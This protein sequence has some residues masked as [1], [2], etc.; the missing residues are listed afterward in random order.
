MVESMMHTSLER[1][2]S[3]KSS[4]A[5]GARYAKGDARREEILRG[6]TDLIVREGY[7]RQSLRE[8]GAALSIEPA[9]ILYYFASREDLLQRVI[10]LWDR[11]SIAS[12]SKDADVPPSLDLF[13]AAVRR[14]C[15]APGIG[16]LF[17]A[18]ATEAADRAHP[19]HDFFRRRVSRIHADLSK[20]IRREQA[21]G[22]IH[23]A[24]DAQLTARQLMALADG[25][26]LQ[27]STGAPIDVVSDLKMT[28]G[29]LRRRT[30]RG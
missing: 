28:I 25:L 14:N 7:R 17:L 2:R 22:A 27:A 29:D 5:R 23:T 20:A 9:H 11:D 24:V 15:E 12:L 30:L 1:P 6:V 10:E 26:Q 16:L 13:V 19:A 3:R 21:Q 4:G 8:I 18:F